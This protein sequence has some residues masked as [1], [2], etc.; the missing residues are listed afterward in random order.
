[1]T[2]ADPIMACRFWL[3]D[4]TA[5][6]IFTDP[7]IQEFLDLEKVTDAD[8]NLP[9]E[10][11]WIPTYDVLR[12][13][14][15]GWLWLAGMAANKPLSYRVGDVSVTYDKNYCLNQARG[16]MGGPCAPLRRRDEQ[17]QPDELDRY[18]TNP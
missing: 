18:R 9:S 8:N 16:L 4:T 7:Q 11:D 12:A 15:R 5:P 2:I 13:A 14:G 6:Y 1:M 10:T 17:T 3:H